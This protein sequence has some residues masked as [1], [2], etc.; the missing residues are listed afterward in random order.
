MTPQND[1]ANGFGALRLLF[2]SLVIFS[3]A[4][5]MIDGDM[6][7]EPMVQVFG[8][9]SLGEFAVM[10][11]FLISGYLI[12]GSFMSDPRG[13][14]AKRV[15]RIYP[16]FVICYLLCIFLVAPLGGANL[17]ALSAGD[18]AGIGVKLVTLK[19][20]AAGP[21]FDGVAYPA[22]NGSMWTI[23]YEFRCYLMAALLGIM[24]LYARPR[25]YL[26]LTVAL[27]LSTFL[28]QTQLGHQLKQLARPT[29][30]LIGELDHTSVLTATFAC[31][32]CFRLFRPNYR[33]RT[34][35][36]CAAALA[37]CLFVPA[38]ARPALM[39]F[40]GY[41]LFWVAFR[42]RNRVLLTLNAK[43]DISYGVYLYAWPIAALLLWYWR[44]VP[45]T[46]LALLSLVAAAV[47]GY[48]SWHVIEKPAM[49]LKQRLPSRAARQAPAAPAADA[50]VTLPAT[51]DGPGT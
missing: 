23:I 50:A 4:P 42:V 22:L 11:F 38:L 46:V 25:W 18:W 37:A 28:F 5:Q 30:G 1:R 3:H 6:S 19:S 33:A 48:V 35:A 27:V 8:T 24:G 39:T 14:I 36:L 2:A 47:C 31:G 17:A 7:R 21:V 16:A 29:N 40:G 44:D 51:S 15:L 45:A 41:V 43:D 9:V 13:Y 49:R 34:A 20:P 32:A 12:T 10:G 26:A